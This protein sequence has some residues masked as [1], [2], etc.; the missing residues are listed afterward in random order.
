MELKEERKT[1]NSDDS[2]KQWT[3]ECEANGQVDKQLID[4]A[5]GLLIDCLIDCGFLSQFLEFPIIP[6][7]ALIFT[8]TP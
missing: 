4:K 1:E 3:D 5:V 7:P 8:Q 2:S 6:L